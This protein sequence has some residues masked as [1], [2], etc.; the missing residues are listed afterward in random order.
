MG[1]KTIYGFI[2]PLLMV[3]TVTRNCITHCS[4]VLRNTILSLL[5]SSMYCE[6]A[7]NTVPTGSCT[8]G[9]YCTGASI[10]ATPADGVTYGGL[11]QSG[12]YCPTASTQMVIDMPILLRIKR[13]LLTLCKIHNAIDK[14]RSKTK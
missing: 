3:C 8:E 13:I 6:G 7:G 14:L 11:C 2:C 4:T 5:N 1:I 12:Y 9:W 10:T